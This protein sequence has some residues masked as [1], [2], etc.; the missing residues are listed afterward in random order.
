MIRILTLLVS[1]FTF[2]LVDLA[3]ITYEIPVTDMLYF[4]DTPIED[5]N[6][7][8]LNEVFNGSQV[9]PYAQSNGIVNLT[10]ISNINPSNYEVRILINTDQHYL[11]VELQYNN[12][13]NRFF[14]FTQ[15]ILYNSDTS[16]LDNSL[17][18]L[19]YKNSSTSP[20]WRF[21]GYTDSNITDTYLKINYL[22]LDDLG[23]TS[24]TKEQLDRY[25]ELWQNPE[26]NITYE[27]NTLDTQDIVILIASQSVW[28]IMIHL[29]Y[30]YAY[31]PKKKSKR[32]GM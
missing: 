9:I 20:F 8:T 6:G 13:H 24:L 7:L 23:L 3:E 18:I 25:Y 11:R 5:L 17:L 22:N 16:G 30:K 10:T 4:N 19:S 15:Q 2:G 27:I 14:I 21:I 12:L 26:L 29:L 1:L 32:L 28:T 31:R